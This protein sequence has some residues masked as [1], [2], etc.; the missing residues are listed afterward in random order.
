MGTILLQKYLRLE[1]VKHLLNLFPTVSFII[2]IKL[3]F[4]SIGMGKSKYNNEKSSE[5]SLKGLD[6]DG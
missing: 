1:E 3:L 2:I 5:D 6:I 4:F